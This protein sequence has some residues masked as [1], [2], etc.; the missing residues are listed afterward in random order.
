MFKSSPDVK[1]APRERSGCEA[2]NKSFPVS[3]TL[4]W[5]FTH[6]PSCFL[7]TVP[8]LLLN[9]RAFVLKVAAFVPTTGAP[10]VMYV[11][12]NFYSF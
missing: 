11:Y 10:K 5:L 1:N 2:I 9:N 3:F 8:I 6:P 4:S 7:C 12:C